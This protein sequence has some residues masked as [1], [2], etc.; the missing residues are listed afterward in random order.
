MLD[1]IP[2]TF[3]ARPR[4]AVVDEGATVEIECRLVAVP[5]PDISWSFNG[6]DLQETDRITWKKISDVHMYHHIVRISD[7]TKEDSGTYKIYAKN[8]EG[9]AETFISLCVEVKEIHECTTSRPNTNHVLK[10]PPNKHQ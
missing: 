1:G 3:A 5:E 8:R 9:E 4:T 7:V 10:W 2:P 6:K